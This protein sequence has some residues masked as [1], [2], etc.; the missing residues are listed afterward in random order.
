MRRILAAFLV[1]TMLGCA[2]LPDLGFGTTGTRLVFTMTMADAIKGNYIYIVAIRPSTD[3]NP[4]EQ[5][6]IP[7]IAPPWGN[8]FVAGTVTHFVQWSPS[9]PDRYELFEF[10]DT[11]LINYRVIGVP[12]TATDV[13]PGI[14][15]TIQFELNLDQLDDIPANAANFETLQINFL[16]MDRIPQGSS[17]SKNWEALGDGRLPSQVNSPITIPVRISGTYNNQTAQFFNLE[18]VGDAA[19]PALDIADWQVEVRRSQ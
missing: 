15:K 5:G 14:S 17:G 18:P 10:V 2:K 19:D 6:P 4:P 8:G 1:V 3:T 13:T 11:T 16:T 12:V 9:F 7:V